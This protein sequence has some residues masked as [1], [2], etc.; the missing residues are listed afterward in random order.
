MEGG[1]GRGETHG[2]ERYVMRP[3]ATVTVSALGLSVR[4]G[5][6]KRGRLSSTCLCPFL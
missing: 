6:L 4:R 5:W 1:R 3:T 2:P